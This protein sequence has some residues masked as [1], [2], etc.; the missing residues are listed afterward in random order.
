MSKITGGGAL[1]FLDGLTEGIIK[2]SAAVGTVKANLKGPSTSDQTPAEG[3][4]SLQSAPFGIPTLWL[5]GG[6]VL[7]AGVV[8]FLRRK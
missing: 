1:S 5:V 2:T 4:S 7:V 6:L 3:V 8:L